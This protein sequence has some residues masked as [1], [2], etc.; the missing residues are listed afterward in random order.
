MLKIIELQFDGVIF[1]D[2]LSMKGAEAVGDFD[3]RARQALQAGCD[4]IL[5]CNNTTAAQDVISALET[6]RHQDTSH[7][8]LAKLMMKQPAKGLE[9]L[10]KSSRWQYLDKQLT[11]FKTSI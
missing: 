1:S 2:D 3:D 6:Y 11:E 7:K 9:Q 8:R 4:M 10:K 5:V